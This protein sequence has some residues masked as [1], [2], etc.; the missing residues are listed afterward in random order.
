MWK[1]TPSWVC[2]LGTIENAFRLMTIGPSRTASRAFKPDTPEIPEAG[3]GKIRGT[4]LQIA[5]TMAAP[6][7]TDNEAGP[8]IIG[9]ARTRGTNPPM[10]G[11][12]CPFPESDDPRSVGVS[13]ISS[14]TTKEEGAKVTWPRCF[15]KYLSQSFLDPTNIALQLVPD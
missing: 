4:K 1:I 13:T 9:N 6:S 2:K 10:A 3:F 5:G 12:T 15:S 7:S 14:M 11:G 8:V